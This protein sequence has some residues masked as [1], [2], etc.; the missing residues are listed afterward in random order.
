[1]SNTI[2]KMTQ[3]VEFIN[4]QAKNAHVNTLICGVSGGIDSAV[5]I[6]KIK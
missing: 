5:P 2:D 1:M 4:D 3:I 6:C